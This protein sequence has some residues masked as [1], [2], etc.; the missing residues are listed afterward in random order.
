MKEHQNEK[1]K[2]L[3]SDLIDT[4][5]NEHKKQDEKITKELAIKHELEMKAQRDNNELLQKQVIDLTNQILSHD[6]ENVKLTNQLVAP[7]LPNQN[8]QDCLK[9]LVNCIVHH[10]FHQYLIHL[11]H[12]N[13]S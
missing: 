2:V 9:S 8:I 6:K 3:R 7:P 12:V 4:F 10:P 1:M 5:K 11:Q 13:Q